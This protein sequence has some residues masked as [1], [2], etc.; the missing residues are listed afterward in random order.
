MS[1]YGKINLLAMLG[2]PIVA[3]LASIIMFGARSDT[4]VFV[5]GINIVP[6][7]IGGLISAL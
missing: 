1:S 3:V 5:F 4:V 2:L 7:L 6:M